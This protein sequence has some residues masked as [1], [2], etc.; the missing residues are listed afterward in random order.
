[1]QAE[2]PTI[3]RW[4]PLWGHKRMKDKTKMDTEGGCKRSRRSFP[5][6]ALAGDLLLHPAHA[7]HGLHVLHAR[8]AAL[9]AV[10]GQEAGGR[11]SPALPARARRAHRVRMRPH[12]RR[13]WWNGECLVTEPGLTEWNSGV[14]SPACRCCHQGSSFQLSDLMDRGVY[15]PLAIGFMLMVFQQMTGINAIMFYAENIFEQAHFKVSLSVA[16]LIVGLRSTWKDQLWLAAAL[17]ESDLASVIVG[18]I[19]VIFTAAAALIMDKAGR[20]FLLIISGT[21]SH[22]E[23]KVHWVFSRC[24]CSPLGH[25]ISSLPGLKLWYH[26][27]VL[28]FWLPRRRH[29]FKHHSVWDL[30]LPDDSYVQPHF[31]WTAD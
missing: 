3:C 9:P 31:G 23:N 16:A 10:E 2:K 27:I 22:Q 13:L 20:K 25:N 17:Q 12:R 26:D 4:C 15:K 24:T 1:M 14:L 18:A 6:L 11:G 5:G 21:S 29:D 7:A 19:Q 28:V 8:D 30:L